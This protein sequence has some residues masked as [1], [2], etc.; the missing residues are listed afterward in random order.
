MLRLLRRSI[1]AASFL[2]LLATV[3]LWVRGYWHSDGLFFQSY[4]VVP[5]STPDPHEID[6]SFFYKDERLEDREVRKEQEARAHS[7]RRTNSDYDVED[8]DPL[9]QLLKSK[10]ARR[11]AKAVTPN[12]KP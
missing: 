12:S 2:L 9:L 5:A 8:D 4:A 3:A 7:Q 6:E 11:S 1:A 10:G